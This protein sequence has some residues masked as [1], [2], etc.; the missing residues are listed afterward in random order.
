MNDKQSTVTSQ[1]MRVNY[2]VI[3]LHYSDELIKKVNKP[4]AV[5]VGGIG[6][7]NY[8]MAKVKLGFGII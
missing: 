7:I 4:D 6:H 5:S 2:M 8:V 1:H 3:E